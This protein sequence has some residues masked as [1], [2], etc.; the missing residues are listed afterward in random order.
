VAL[1]V[2][3]AGAHQAEQRPATQLSRT[4]LM[5]STAR[6]DEVIAAHH[7]DAALHAA[8]LDTACR[9]CCCVL[10][11][12]LGIMVLLLAGAPA[13]RGRGGFRGEGRGRG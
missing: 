1:V 4:A 11:F 9:S 7:Q 12:F 6:I 2:D 8:C 5:V 10:A 13:A 3:W